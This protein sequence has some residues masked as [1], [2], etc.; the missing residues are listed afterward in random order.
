MELGRYMSIDVAVQEPTVLSDLPDFRDFP[1]EDVATTSVP[2][3][4]DI[5]RRILPLPSDPQRPSVS[6][7]NSSI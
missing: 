5:M 3:I 6:A 1:I 2:D 7:F 4:A